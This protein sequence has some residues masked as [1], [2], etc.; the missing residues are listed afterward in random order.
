MT[1]SADICCGYCGVGGGSM[2]FPSC[3]HIYHEACI[4]YLGLDITGALPLYSCKKCGIQ[5]LPTK[6]FWNE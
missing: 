2:I 5:D 3:G 1:F 6:V 4:E